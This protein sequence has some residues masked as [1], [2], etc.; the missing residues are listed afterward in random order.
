MVRNVVQNHVVTLVTFGEILFRVIDDMICAKRS[1]HVYNPRAAYAGH[2]CAERLR[3]L[4]RERAYTSRRPVN[5]GLLPRL[6]LSLVAK[7]LQCR[8][9]GDIDRSCLLE[10]QVNRL[11]RDGSTL[12]NTHILSKGP[13]SP[14]K[15]LIAR[16]ELCDVLADRL[17]CPRVID[18]Q[19]CVLWFSQ[20]HPHWT[21][22]VGRAFN[23]VPVE[24]IHCRGV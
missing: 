11:P 14:A 13:I 18:A 9:A 8:D 5:Q 16:F 15:Y 24:R 23:E 20:A 17:N 10:G 1:D 19:S 12:A 21:H 3:D 4:H 22:D 2:I 7:S 6:N